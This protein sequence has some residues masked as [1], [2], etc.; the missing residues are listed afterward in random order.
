MP[1]SKTDVYREGNYVYIAK[2]EN[3]YCPVSIL[4][5]YV[6][7]ANLDL[8]SNLPL[9]RPLSKTE[10]GYTLRNSKLSYTRCREI[11]KA[12]LKEL[13][14]DPNIMAC[15]VCVL[16]VLPLLSVMISLRPFLRGYINSMD[17]GKL[18]RR[19]ICMFWPRMQPIESKRN[20]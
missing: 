9:F 8:S 20:V 14:Y 2:L 10:S 15:I 18:T 11:F 19:R 3:N 16:V 4:Q 13:G 6:E 12:A 5:K 1:K 7:A 17:A